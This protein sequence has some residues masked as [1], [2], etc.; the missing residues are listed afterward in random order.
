MG[1]L[2]EAASWLQELVVRKS[3]PVARVRDFRSSDTQ[4]AATR[5]PAKVQGLLTAVPVQL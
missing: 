4:E 2:S 1:M 5:P 3:N